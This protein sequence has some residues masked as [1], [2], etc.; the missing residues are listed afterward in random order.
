[1]PWDLLNATPLQYK[2][3]LCFFPLC[4]WNLVCTWNII[5]FL[6]CNSPFI[7]N[8][9]SCIDGGSRCF[10]VTVNHVGLQ[11]LCCGPSTMTNNYQTTTNRCID[12]SFLKNCGLQQEDRA[13]KGNQSRWYQHVDECWASGGLRCC[14]VLFC[15]SC[16]VLVK[17]VCWKLRSIYGRGN[18]SC[19]GFCQPK[20]WSFVFIINIYSSQQRP[21]NDQLGNQCSI[22][23]LFQA[24]ALFC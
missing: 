15:G 3:L 23:C 17:F 18:V 1:M 14:Q 21:S 4:W 19:T 13:I 20:S 9:S 10:Q 22:S 16:S 6:I 24:S 5:G 8:G 11:W 12:G 7:F 2:K